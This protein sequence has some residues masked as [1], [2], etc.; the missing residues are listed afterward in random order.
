M[1]KRV[2]LRNLIS[3]VCLITFLISSAYATTDFDKEIDQLSCKIAEKIAAAGKKKIAVVD[4]TDLDGTVT[5]L[6]RFLAEEFSTALAGTGKG[7]T[8]VDRI[9]LKTLLKE[10][11]LSST[12]LID[13]NTIRQ[14]GKIAGVDSLITGSLTPLG[15][16]VR[17]NVKVLDIETAALI[18]ANRG[19]FAMTDAIK[20][21]MRKGII[22]PVSTASGS[23]STPIRT[24]VETVQKIEE[25]NFVFEA[26]GCKV[27]G[28]NVIFSLLITN[29][30][31]DG[32]FLIYFENTSLYDDFGNEYPAKKIQL[33]SE[34][35]PNFGRIKKVLFSGVPTKTFLKFEDVSPQATMAMAVVLNCEGVRDND[36]KKFAVKFRGITFSR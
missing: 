33:G 10:H 8:V 6:G 1:M 9:H 17:I 2:F 34:S 30:N 13:Q 28:K 11:K 3:T 15:E 35:R 5:E 22:S 23:S 27:S 26:I 32:E 12:G 21:L 24:R 36:W 7:F 16:I 25:Q 18:D 14:L 19:N 31:K 29:K 20:D 4:F